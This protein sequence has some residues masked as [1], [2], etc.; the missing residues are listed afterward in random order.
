MK[1]LL[2]ALMILSTSI[3]Y[4]QI[5]ITS[6]DMPISGDTLRYTNANFIFANIN[7]G[8]SG[9]NMTW[10]YSDLQPLTQ[11]VDT[12]KTALSVNIAYALISLTAYGYKVADSFPGSG[13]F[14]PVSINQLYTF[15]QKKSSPSRYSAIAFAAKIAGLPTPFNYTIDD[16]WYYFPLTYLNS[17]SSNFS[18]TIG[19]SG[20]A[21]IKQT[22][23]RKTRVDGWG[24]ITTPYFTSPVSCIRVRSYIH[25]VDSIDFGGFPLHIPRNT[26]E[27]KWMV[28]GEHYPALWV[29][30]TKTDTVESSGN[31]VINSVKYRDMARNLNVGVV[32][33]QIIPGGISAFP[34]PAVNGLTHLDIPESNTDFS[35]EL[36]DIHSRCLQTTRNQRDLDLRQ[37]PKG[38]Y[39]ARVT[40]GQQYTYVKLEN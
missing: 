19:I 24:T 12:Y 38:M 35:V 27:Y 1:R 37:L 5:T 6:S 17:D 33:R 39:V 22:G 2:L 31:E 32:A 21:S 16:D 7:L 4:G 20:T 13:S 14:I 28:N 26:V 29:T 18:L 15:F 30:A 36:F 3:S 40:I 9:A 11:A 23:Y 8:D 25:E 34:N 10:N